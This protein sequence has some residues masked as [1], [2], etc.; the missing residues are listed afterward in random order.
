MWMSYLAI[1]LP[2][3]IKTKPIDGRSANKRMD[4]RK[5][6]MSKLFDTSGEESILVSDCSGGF[7]TRL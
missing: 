7:E 3:R 6:E 2:R 5:L 4:G 1:C